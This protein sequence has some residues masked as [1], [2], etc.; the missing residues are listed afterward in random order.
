MSDN[1]CVM[2]IS[3]CLDIL[4]AIDPPSIEKKRI[5]I[6]FKK[7]I[8]PS[9]TDEYV[10]WYTIHDIAMDCIHVPIND[11]IWPKKNKR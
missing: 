5:G 10:N 11:K 9:Q 1:T 2:M 7:P 8:V 3:V 6:E 4:S